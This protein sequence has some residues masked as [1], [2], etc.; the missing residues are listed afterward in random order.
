M[1]FGDSAVKRRFRQ[2]NEPLARF[3][4]LSLTSLMSKLVGCEIKPSYCYAASYREGADLKPHVDRE[5]CEYSFSLQVDYEPEPADGI[6]PWPLWLSTGK[7][8]ED[9]EDG[10]SLEWSD[11]PPDEK[12]ERSIILGN[13]D[14]LAYRGRALAHYRY[15]LPPG[16]RSTSLFF[17]YVPLDFDDAMI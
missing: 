6:S 7:Y 4:H 1:P 17:H 14:C 16:H 13:G 9:V 8:Y 11:R 3:F 2:A 10:H 5:A 15:E 12:T